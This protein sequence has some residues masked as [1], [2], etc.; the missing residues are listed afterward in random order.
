MSSMLGTLASE[1]GDAVKRPER[2]KETNPIVPL[3]YRA[4]PAPGPK[5]SEDEP[6]AGNEDWNRLE[7][8]EFRSTNEQHPIAEDTEPRTRSRPH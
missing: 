2:G 4:Q 7:N 8:M 1:G 6:N 3:L 5:R